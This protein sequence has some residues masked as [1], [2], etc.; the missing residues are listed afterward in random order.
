[1]TFTLKDNA[2]R[3]Y[4]QIGNS[5][6]GATAPPIGD[7]AATCVIKEVKTAGRRKARGSELLNIGAYGLVSPIFHR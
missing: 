2:R 4:I 1:V 7:R 3:G 6:V 5:V